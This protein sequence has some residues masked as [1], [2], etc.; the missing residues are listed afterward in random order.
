MA[1][2]GHETM[3]GGKAVQVDLIKRERAPCRA[4]NGQTGTLGPG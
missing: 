4:A 3:P 1:E 2:E